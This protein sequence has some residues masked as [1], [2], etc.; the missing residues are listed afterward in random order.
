MRRFLQCTSCGMKFGGEKG[1]KDHR[2]GRF[3]DVHPHYG[4]NC[5]SADDLVLK[6]Y[7]LNEHGAFGKPMPADLVRRLSGRA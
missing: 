7:V 4:R 6:G 1:F 5:L 2:T 3:E